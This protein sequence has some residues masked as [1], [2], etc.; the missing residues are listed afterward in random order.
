MQ[1]AVFLA[2]CVKNLDFK[3][4]YNIDY[5]LGEKYGTYNTGYAQFN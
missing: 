4:L 2:N 1:F 5:A 3:F